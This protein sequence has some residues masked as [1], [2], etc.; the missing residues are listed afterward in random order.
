MVDFHCHLDLYPKPVAVVNQCKE[1]QLYVLSVTTTPSAW[2]G[3][4]RIAKDCPKIRTALGLHPQLAHQR[5]HELEMFDALIS[6]AKYVGEIGLDGSKGFKPFM[7]AQLKV[8][9][10]I[11]KTVNQAGGRV[12]S[13][14][15]RS[16]AS[17]V[18]SELATCDGI[19]VYHWFTGNKTELKQVISMGGWFS[20]SP[21]MLSTKRGF[22]LVSMMPRDRVLP[23]TDGPF[24]KYKGSPLMPWHVDLVFDPLAK[25]WNVDKQEAKDIVQSNFRKLVSFA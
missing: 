17:A 25:I 9:R 16:S 2:S 12:M 10:H 13:I 22:E 15:S 19:P 5:S 21:A 11:L 20:V 8:F 4:S 23:E 18:I 6:E 7:E 3:T 14:H 1:K 24:A